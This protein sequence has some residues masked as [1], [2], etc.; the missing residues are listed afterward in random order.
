MKNRQQ[1]R[2]PQHSALPIQYPSKK[3]TV[4]KEK[5]KASTKKKDKQPK[6]NQ[7]II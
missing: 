7:K 3:R 5:R 6:G 4:D 2:H 1:R